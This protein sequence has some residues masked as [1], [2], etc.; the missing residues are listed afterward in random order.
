MV[1]IHVAFSICKFEI[2]TL[3]FSRCGPFIKASRGAIDQLGF[4]NFCLFD[5]IHGEIIT[6]NFT[7]SILAA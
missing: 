2:E 1:L 3:L 7:S 6:R 5:A 4:V